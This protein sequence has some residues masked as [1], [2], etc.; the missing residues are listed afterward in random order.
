MF[1]EQ[2]STKALHS[3]YKSYVHPQDGVMIYKISYKGK[4]LVYATDKEC[5]LGGDKKFIN[6]AKII[7][8]KRSMEKEIIIQNEVKN[9]L[10]QY[11]LNEE[12]RG[13]YV[14]ILQEQ[15]KELSPEIT[16][17]DFTKQVKEK[18]KLF[19]TSAKIIQKSRTKINQSAQEK[20][21]QI[22]ELMAKVEELSKKTTPPDV[23]TPQ[24]PAQEPQKKDDTV[25]EMLKS[26]Q[27]KMNKIEQDRE[28]EKKEKQLN[29]KKTN[30]LQAVKKDYSKQL[31]PIID[32]IAKSVDF[33]LDDAEDNFKKN[34]S[35]WIKN[36]ST[37]IPKSDDFSDG[38]INIENILGLG[39]EKQKEEE[40]RKKML[41]EKL[42]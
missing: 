10:S 11:G 39:K 3:F 5:Y 18:V 33:S 1:N 32:L 26:M 14:N 28:N 35:D 2:F 38:N 37:S 22:K 24:E 30:I 29:E 31:E 21:T 41:S 20:D 8:T 34:V 16:E 12:E 13:S 7:K 36:N 19:E 17:E 23:K 25:L 9:G 42:I 6:F 27:D 40:E 4:S 15:F